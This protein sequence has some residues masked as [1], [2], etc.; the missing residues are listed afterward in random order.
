MSTSAAQVH[1]VLVASTT[2][3]RTPSRKQAASP[4][5]TRRW[6]GRIVTAIP[7]LFILFDSVIKL[8]VIPPVTESFIRLGYSPDVAVGIG[9]LELACLIV[10]LIP[11]TSVVGAVLLTGFLG[12]AIATHVRVGDPLFSHVLFPTYIAALLWGG[13][14]LRH[15]RLRALLTLVTEN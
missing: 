14:Q 10:Y 12:G 13:L 9:L 11:R 2:S 8:I 1:E 6:A 3:V 5:K 7:V 15:P 4:T